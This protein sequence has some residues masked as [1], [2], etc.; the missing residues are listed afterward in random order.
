MSWNKQE[1]QKCSL[2]GKILTDINCSRRPGKE[3]HRF[4]S[5]CR[6]CTKRLDRERRVKNL[7]I[8]M[9]YIWT[10]H[11][12]KCSRCG[13]D[14]WEALEFHHPDPRNGD[15][16]K[17]VGNSIHTHSPHTKRGQWLREEIKKCELVYANC[18]R[19]IHAEL[20]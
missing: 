11:K 16:S 6:S 8:W 4:R 3:S 9:E 1:V 13:F 12:C 2:C 18:H 17:C 5:W 10:V 14:I 15:I 20:I 7:K 19:L